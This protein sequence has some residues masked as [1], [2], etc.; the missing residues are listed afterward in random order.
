MNFLPRYINLPTR[1]QNYL[2]WH[3]KT[4]ERWKTED[5][6]IHVTRFFCLTSPTVLVHE[7]T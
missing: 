4:M 1:A 2:I 6:L 5:M 7:E 3:V